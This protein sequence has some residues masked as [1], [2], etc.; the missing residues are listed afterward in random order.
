MDQIGRETDELIE[1]TILRLKL[2][3]PEVYRKMVNASR[4]NSGKVDLDKE[5]AE[6]LSPMIERRMV[7]GYGLQSTFWDILRRDL[8]E[9]IETIIS[10]LDALKKKESELHSGLVRLKHEMK[11]SDDEV[12]AE[13]GE[14]LVPFKLAYQDEQGT[15][16]LHILAYN[17][18][19]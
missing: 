12:P 8:G 16:R 5:T 4:T 3:K 2:G 9:D 6:S 7:G 18:T 15:Y 14:K 19:R 1:M 13:I 11:T 17:L 10:I